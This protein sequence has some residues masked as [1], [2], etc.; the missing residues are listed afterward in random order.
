M[1][2]FI[3]QEKY[4]TFEIK[5][6]GGEILKSFKIDVGNYDSLR[7]WAGQIAEVERLS[8]EAI[9]SESGVES[10]MKLEET[11]ISMVL[12]HDGWIWLWDAAKHNIFACLGVVKALS[13]I[14]KEEINSFQEEYV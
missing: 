5:N 9:N 11:V 2:E 4:K 13:E 10:L 12:G 3:L 6:I 14:V 1:A 8:Q 7:T